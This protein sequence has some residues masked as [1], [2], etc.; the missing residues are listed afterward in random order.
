MVRGPKRSRP[1]GI[2]GIGVGY[3]ETEIT[4]QELIE[5]YNICGAKGPKTVEEIFQTTGILSRRII[6]PDQDV[7]D[8]G[9]MAAIEA[10]DSAG[11]DPK[12]IGLIVV[13]TSS[14][15]RIY[16]S[17]ACNIQA[18]L[19][20]HYGERILCKCYDLSAACSGFVYS[21]ETVVGELTGQNGKYYQFALVIGAEALSRTVK[22]GEPSEDSQGDFREWWKTFILFGDYASAVVLGDVSS[23]RGFYNFFSTADGRFGPLAESRGCGTHHLDYELFREPQMYVNG[24]EVMKYAIRTLTEATIEVARRDGVSQELIADTYDLFVP[25][26]ANSRITEGYRR[27]LGIPTEKMVNNIKDKGNTSNASIGAG[28]YE[29]LPQ[30]GQLIMLSG[31]GGGLTWGACSLRWGR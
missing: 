30:D 4:T 18:K 29:N 21:L 14:P 31:V 17:T 7:S 19:I 20:E 24:P 2:L 25:H 22:W 10:I 11:I 28:L 6:D 12:Q 9:A 8:L 26:Q 1:I 16:P 13:P 5:K 3:P 27:Q 15:E 23:N